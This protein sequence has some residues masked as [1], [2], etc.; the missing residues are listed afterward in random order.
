MDGCKSRVGCSL[1]RCLATGE[2]LQPASKLERYLATRRDTT[3]PSRHNAAWSRRGAEQLIPAV[4][5]A[6]CKSLKQ[7]CQPLTFLLTL[8]THTCTR[9]R[10]AGECSGEGHGERKCLGAYLMQ[11]IFLCQLQLP[12]PYPQFPGRLPWKLPQPNCWGGSNG[13]SDHEEQE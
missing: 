3:T 11:T 12:S 2:Q 8:N 4:K 5:Q 6:G 13:L 1:S 10:G 9:Q 7:C